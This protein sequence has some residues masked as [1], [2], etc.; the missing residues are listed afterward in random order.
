MGFDMDDE[1][2]VICQ[3]LDGNR[4]DTDPCKIEDLYAFK[5]LLSHNFFPFPMSI[6]AIHG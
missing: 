1:C 6:M 4:P 3:V 2:A 5:Y